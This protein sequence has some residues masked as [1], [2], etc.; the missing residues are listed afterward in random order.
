MQITCPHCNQPFDIDDPH[1]KHINEKDLNMIVIE[2][3]AEN[4]TALVTKKLEI[5]TPTVGDIEKN[6]FEHNLPTGDYWKEEFNKEIIVLHYTAGYTWQGAYNTFKLPGR[7]ATPFIIDKEGPKYIVKLFDEKYWSYHLGIK[8][9]KLSKNWINDKRS[10]GIEIVNIGTV[11][12]ED[13]QWRDYVQR[14][15]KV[16]STP[17]Q[18]IVKSK[19]RDADGNVKF[20]EKQVD[21]VCDLVNYLCDKWNIPRQVPKDKMSVQLPQITEFKGITTHQMFRQDKYDMGVAWPWER[22]IEKCGLQEIAL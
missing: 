17:E 16:G 8:D 14:M 7:I 19:N 12:N 9:E 6:T 22:M 21:A 2:E 4:I 18:D 15:K 13:G 1:R 11:W 20:P 10:I 3:P 5:A